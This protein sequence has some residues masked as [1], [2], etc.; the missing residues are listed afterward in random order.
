MEQKG[1][2]EGRVDEAGHSPVLFIMEKNQN[3]ESAV[4]TN[5]NRCKSNRQRRSHIYYRSD[6]KHLGNVTN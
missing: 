3:I 1:A 5:Y 6:Q 2:V 4:K